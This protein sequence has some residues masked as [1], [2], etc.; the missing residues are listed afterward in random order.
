MRHVVLSGLMATGKS[1]LGPRVAARLD[2]PFVDIDDAIALAS[3][4]SVAELWT[5]V[6]E[7][8]FRAIEERVIGDLLRAE[9]PSV[10]SF[11]GGAVTT[12]SV[13]AL[14]LSRAW[15][16]TLD[17]APESLVARI[18]D[19]SSRPQ[20][21]GQ[22]VHARLT[23][24]REQRA[25]AYAECHERIATD[26]V[27]IDEGVAAVVELSQRDPILVPL[28]KRSYIIEIAIDEPSRLTRAI[29]RLAPS[30]VVA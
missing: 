28:G 9:A 4:K 26:R 10:L 5:S 29:G 27:G 13:R 18:V 21:A 1:T 24:L 23:E 15:V 2:W 16:V 6:G 12:R 11:G 19:P 20:L 14:A 25:E 22:D 3:S 30:R 8:G 7:A 17:A